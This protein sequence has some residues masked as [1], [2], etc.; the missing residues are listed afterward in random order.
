M[1]IGNLWDS[2]AERSLVVLGGAVSFLLLIVCAN[3][4]NLTVS[5]SIGRARDLAVRTALG[6]SRRDLVRAAMVEYAVLG[7]AGAAG[8][9]VVAGA[10][11]QATVVLLPDAMTLNSLNPIDL[12]VRTLGFLAAATAFTVLASG[13][14][15]ALWSSRASVAALLRRDARTAS[16]SGPARH[17][18]ALLVTTEVALS[19]VLLVGAALMTRSVLNLQAIDTGI[20]TDGL[21]SMRV[22][23]PTGG[24]ADESVRRTFTTDLLA[25]LRSQP[26]ITAVSAGELP[27]DHTMVS[28][29]ALEFGERPGQTTATTY[30]DAYAP[31]PGYFAT[32]GIDLIEGREFGGEEREPVA[33]VSAGFAAAHWPGASAVGR[34]FRFGK[35]TWRTVVGVAAEIRGVTGEDD[36]KTFEVYYPASQLGAVMRSVRPVS[37]IAAYQTVVVRADRPGLVA[38]DLAAAVHAVDPRVIVSRIRLVEH[39]FADAIARPRVVLL[40]MS[41]F[42]GVGLIL[43]AAGLYGVLSHLV[44][45]RQREIGIRLALGASPVEVGR[46]ILGSGLGLALL[47]AC[48]GAVITMPLVGAMRTLLYEVEPVDPFSIAAV[49]A[50]V[51]GTAVLASWWPARRAMRVDPLTLMRAE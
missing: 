4:A 50:L 21:I 3:V 13:L 26:G 29:G 2:R 16:G 37:T 5:R 1:T 43:A 33:I 6:A 32:T 44:Q 27:P 14:P 25:R 15:A 9:L 11:I 38:R 42:A 22:A 8:G 36:S 40:M 49:G 47:G 24:Y 7:A 41:V 28:Y 46:S 48:A 10:A 18:R 19:I 39:D 51:V 45:Q 17:L 20:D 30:A 34:R 12:D 35:D 31:W 23:L